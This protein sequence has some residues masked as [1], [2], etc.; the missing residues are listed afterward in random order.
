VGVAG[1]LTDVESLVALKDFLNRLG[2]ENLYTEEGFPTAGPGTDLRSNYILNSGI[3]GIEVNV[4]MSLLW[5]TCVA[6]A[7][8]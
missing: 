4:K 7:V 3:N 6:W 8:K 2:S 1:G 5:Y